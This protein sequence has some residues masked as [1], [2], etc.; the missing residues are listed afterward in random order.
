MSKTKYRKSK[1]KH[2]AE[3]VCKIGYFAERKYWAKYFKATS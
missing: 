2:F 3:L 1:E